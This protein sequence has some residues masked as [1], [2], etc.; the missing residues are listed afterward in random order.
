LPYRRREKQ[1][2]PPER[3]RDTDD[4]AEGIAAFG[5]RRQPVVRGR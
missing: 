1:I 3:V 2:L 5:E 4:F